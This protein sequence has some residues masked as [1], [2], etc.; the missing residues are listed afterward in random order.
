MQPVTLRIPGDYWDCQV[1]RGRLYLWRMDGRLVIYDWDRLVDSLTQDPG[2]LFALRC[3]F[4][5]GDYLYGPGRLMLL[6]PDFADLMRNK[7]GNIAGRPWAPSYQALAEC[8]LGTQDDP[9]DDLPTDTELYNSN[10]YGATDSGLWRVTAHLDG[11]KHKVSPHPIK[12]WD[13]HIYSVRASSHGGRLALAAGSDGLFEYHASSNRHH[14]LGLGQEGFVDWNL[15]RIHPEH[16]SVANWSYSSIYSSSYVGHGY[17]AAFQP[18]RRRHADYNALLFMGVFSQDEIFSESGDGL[19]WGSQDKIYRIRPGGLDVVSYSQRRLDKGE[20]FYHKTFLPFDGWK[21]QIEGG[22]AA[23]FGVVVQCENAV[24]VIRSDN[25]PSCNFPG[26]PVRWRIYPRSNCYQ[27]HLHVIYEQHIDI[28][29]FNHDY[30]VK[31]NDKQAGIRWHQFA[32][33]A[34]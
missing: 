19:S 13:G 28:I 15:V 21:G 3:A 23:L 9:F 33:T 25:Q 4:S 5:R 32:W 16:S 20:A 29:S 31:Q 18:E 14:Y 30:F 17:L 10:L 11:K 24:V 12:V 8:T 34:T 2:E 26:S 1:Y 6:D 27:N 7:L 22:G